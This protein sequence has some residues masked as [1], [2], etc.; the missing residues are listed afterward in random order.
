PTKVLHR[1][2]CFALLLVFNIH[3][4]GVDHAFVFLLR[5][6]TL[7]VPTR[8]RFSASWSSSRSA[9]RLRSLI[10]LLRQLVRSG[11]QLLARRI[12]LRLVA[13]FDGLLRVRQCVF[14]VAALRALD[15]V[16]MLF[17]H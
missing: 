5:L 16:A 10:H 6:L 13:A 11:S 15:L 3:V 14:D 9:R 4:L 12:H 8:S 2:R 7:A 17:Q 1:E